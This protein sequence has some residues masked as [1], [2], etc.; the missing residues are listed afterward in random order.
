MSNRLDDDLRRA[1][2]MITR[3][4]VNYSR[5]ADDLAFAGHVSPGPCDSCR[6]SGRDYCCPACGRAANTTQALP[7][8]GAAGRPRP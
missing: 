5:T 7:S 3:P 4:G 8:E 6:P 1:L 2:A